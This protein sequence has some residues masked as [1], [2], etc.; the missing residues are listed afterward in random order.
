[1]LSMFS[2]IIEIAPSFQPKQQLLTIQQDTYSFKGKTPINFNRLDPYLLL[3][4]LNAIG[5]LVSTF[6]VDVPFSMGSC[7]PFS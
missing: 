6:L 7:R 5:F 2:H 1:M 3:I 4:Y